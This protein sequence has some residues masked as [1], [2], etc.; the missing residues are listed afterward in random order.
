ML[1]PQAVQTHISE[2]SP[3]ADKLTGPQGG[4]GVASGD[5]VLQ[6][7]DVA[8]TVI[9]ALD[10]ERFLV[11]PHP[12]VSEYVRRKASDTDRWLEGMRRFQDR[13]FGSK[14]PADWLSE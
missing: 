3:D 4:F 6:S 12:E 2:N 13:V 7:S 1:C 8:Q 14:G 11:L 10:E 9:E 5:G